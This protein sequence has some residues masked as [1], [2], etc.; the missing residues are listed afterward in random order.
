MVYNA[1][2]EH[3]IALHKPVNVS[4]VPKRSPFRYP[5]GK[6]WLVPHIRRWLGSLGTRPAVFCEPFAGGGIISL[7]VAFEHLA[8]HVLMVELDSQV[9]AVWHTLLE[10]GGADWLAERVT[11]FDLSSETLR[12]E[13]AQPA[14]SR[15]EM[16]FQ[17]LLKN[18]TYHGGILAPG[19]SPTKSGEN[20]RGLLSR[21]YPTT[22]AQRVRDIGAMRDRIEFV[23]GDG[24]TVLS[25]HPLRD[26]AVW[27]LDP[28]YT[29]S[30]KHAGS[31]LYRHYM[32][33]HARLFDLACE[34][35]GDF[36]MTYDSAEEIVSLA[37]SHRLD[38]AL[39]AM[40][41]THNATMYE[42]LVGRDLGWASL[43][44]A[45]PLPMAE[46]ATA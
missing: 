37:S 18:R 12:A 25:E 41:N 31:R 22:L 28:P 23:Q 27:F 44:V 3:T 19:S 2:M 42:L 43:P 5:G 10:P 15:R 6:T 34:L 36:L 7:T 17:T 13:L 39:V 46:A 32:L 8:D 1:G 26:D 20:G 4:T 16:A 35:R 38:T 24:M 14:S 40:R 45:L 11:G 33:D 30:R 9:A 29:A 21:W